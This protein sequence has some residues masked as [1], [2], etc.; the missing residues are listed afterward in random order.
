MSKETPV[1]Y[2]ELLDRNLGDLSSISY[3][4][5]LNTTQWFDKRQEIFLRDNFT[6]QMCDKLID[7]SKH[8][9]LGWTSIRVDSLGETCW[10]P[11]QVHHAYYILHTVPWDYPNDALVTI[12]A[13]CHQDYHNKNKVPVYNE[14]GVAVEVET[15]KR[16]NGSGWFFEYRHVQ[17]GLC[18]ECH[19]E[20]F[21]RRLK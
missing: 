14:D 17:D 21:S 6:C 8:R 2:H 1:D 9:F 19:G 4:E 5:L 3:V 20:R 16:C 10:I 12:C 11:L 18:F 13:T 7:N 15:C